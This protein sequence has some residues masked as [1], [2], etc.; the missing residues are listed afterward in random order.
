MSI[1]VVS[2]WAMTWKCV[3][4]LTVNRGSEGPDRTMLMRKLIWTFAVALSPETVLHGAALSICCLTYDIAS[5][6]KFILCHIFTFT[7]Y[8][9]VYSIFVCHSECPGQSARMRRD[10]LRRVGWSG[11]LPIKASFL[12]FFF[13][14]GLCNIIY[15]FYNVHIHCGHGRSRPD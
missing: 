8:F 2:R 5:G 1:W 11:S 3:V 4:G 14:L 9:L 15:S 6:L 13:S 10:L 12:P 7:I